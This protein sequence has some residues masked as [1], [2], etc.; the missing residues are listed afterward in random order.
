MIQKESKHYKEGEKE[1]ETERALK[2]ERV[3]E[4][5]RQRKRD[6]ERETWCGWLKS[7]NPG[8]HDLS[9]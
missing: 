8:E 7:H 1:Q 9:F 2:L 5:E 6:R 3:R 4:R